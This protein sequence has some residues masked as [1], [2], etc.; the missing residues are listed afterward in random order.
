M[1]I[2]IFP[3]LS[4]KNDFYPGVMLSEKKDHYI[5]QLEDEL[6]FKEKI[7][8]FLNYLITTVSLE[9]PV[10]NGLQTC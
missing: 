10:K 1:N 8:V 3:H 9:Q 4:I 2:P 7:K 5:K 6:L